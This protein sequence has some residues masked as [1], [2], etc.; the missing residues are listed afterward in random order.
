MGFDCAILLS[1]DSRYLP[2]VLH[3]ARQLLVHCPKRQFDILI[4]SEEALDPPD[5]ALREG[6]RFVQA[7]AGMMP[8]DLP[9]KRL[10]RATYLKLAFPALLAGQ[11]RRMLCLDA[12][13]FMEGGDIDRLL[14]LPMGDHAV[15]ASRDTLQFLE[16]GFHAQEYRALGWPAAPYLN[17]GVLLI[18]CAAWQR[19]GLYDRCLAVARETPEAMHLHDQSMLNVALRGRFA[20]L[21][22]AW[23]WQW[24][25]SMPFVPRAF[26]VRFRHFLGN[27]KPWADRQE[28]YDTRFRDSYAA[29]FR[30]FL[31]EMADTLPP[32]PE[33]R[34]IALDL[35]VRDLIRHGKRRKIFA[36]GLGRFR[37]EWH[38]RL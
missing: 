9:L 34:L 26:P 29:F 2:Y 13:V 17:G 5:W 23:N 38:L 18:D 6:L 15:A 14:R 27:K 37:D 32:P 7:P 28:A 33:P 19:T 35:L 24:N 31:P 10:P 1:C 21:S 22:P 25:Q 36:H 11:Y 16:P 3:L 20:E 12:D 30:D 8:D 4:G